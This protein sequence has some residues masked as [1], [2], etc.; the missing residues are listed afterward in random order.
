[1]LGFLGW[2]GVIGRVTYLLRAVLEE[3]LETWKCD[4]ITAEVSRHGGVGQGGP[5]LHVDLLVEALLT[6]G[7]E[8]LTSEY[9]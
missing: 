9:R 1:M 6:G 8:V 7:N 5:L 3:L 4:I 2:L